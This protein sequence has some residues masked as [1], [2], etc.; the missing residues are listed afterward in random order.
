MVPDAPSTM[1]A[2]LQRQQPRSG[3]LRHK[4]GGSGGMTA[5]VTYRELGWSG[6]FAR[7]YPKRAGHVRPI[8][9]TAQPRHQCRGYSNGSARVR[10]RKRE[11]GRNW[12]CNQFGSRWSERELSTTRGSPTL[13]M[14]WRGS[15]H[16]IGARWGQA[17]GEGG[18]G[19][20]VASQRSHEQGGVDPGGST[21]LEETVRV[22]RPWW[23][24][25]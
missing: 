24:R 8:G 23:Q 9:A 4:E 17:R 7:A 25:R 10:G 13:T 2:N 12:W 16:K 22:R 1:T 21:M 18:V 14:R 6:G 3:E 11:V 19:Q 20:L 15:A 5:L